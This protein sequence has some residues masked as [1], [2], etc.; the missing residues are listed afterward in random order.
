M[1][2]PTITNTA[3]TKYH[4]QGSYISLFW[5]LFRPILMDMIPVVIIIHA[6][7]YAVNIIYFLILWQEWL[8]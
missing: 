7:I 3:P 2:L 6:I 5:L 8:S 1:I 4:P